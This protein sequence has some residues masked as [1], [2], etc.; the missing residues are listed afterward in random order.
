MEMAQ[1]PAA[2]LL[3][4]TYLSPSFRAGLPRPNAAIILALRL[5]CSY[6]LSAA[7][8][9]PPQDTRRGLQGAEVGQEKNMKLGLPSL[10]GA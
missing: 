2:S 5:H 10:T 1:L 3:G 8:S 6:L 7:P 9:R 4:L